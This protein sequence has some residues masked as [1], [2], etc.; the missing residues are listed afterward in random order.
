MLAL[1][2]LGILTAIAV[3]AGIVVF[4]VTGDRKYLRFA[5]ELFRWAII[6]ALAF[7]ALI[8]LERLISST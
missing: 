8:I 6:L 7:F 1:R 3:G 4:I 2:I 5:L